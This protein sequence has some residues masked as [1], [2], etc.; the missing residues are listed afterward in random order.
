M[1]QYNR[2][3]LDEN[4]TYLGLTDTTVL[5]D[6]EQP[7]DIKFILGLLNSK[8]L[9][10]R[11]RFMS[12]LKSGGIYE[13][14]WNNISKIPIKRIDLNNQDEKELHDKIVTSVQRIIELKVRQ[15]KEKSEY[16]KNKLNDLIIDCDNLIDENV[17][18]L[19]NL[20]TEEIDFVINSTQ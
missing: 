14:F 4:N 16:E 12:K 20:T 17:F 3:A 5:F 13:Y 7:E 1:A 10:F 19:Y 6:N 8:L 15:E 11:F 2:F 18:K 9:T